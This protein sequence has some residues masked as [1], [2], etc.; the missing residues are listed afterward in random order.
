[1]RTRGFSIAWSFFRKSGS[2]PRLAVL[3]QVGV[4]RH[5]PVIDEPP[6]HRGKHAT[7]AVTIIS[8]HPRMGP[9]QLLVFLVDLANVTIM[10]L[11]R[12]VDCRDAVL[13]HVYEAPRDVAAL[14]FRLEDN[15]AAMRRTGIGAEHAEEIRKA[16]HRQ[17]E[18]GGRI[19]ICPY[20]PQ[21]LA[22]A[23]RDI[24]TRRHFGH[25]EA[26]RDDNQVRGPQLALGGNNA[27]PGETV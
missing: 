27:I 14:A 9:D 17:A 13:D 25:L 24:E 8:R 22:A 16:R 23:P 5:R 7:G 1:M 15:A 12:N 18:I 10:R 26:G 19:I 2:G 3:A 21:V 20:I 6:W 4:V 11:L